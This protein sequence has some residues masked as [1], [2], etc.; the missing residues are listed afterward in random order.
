[1]KL[2]IRFSLVAVVALMA[3]SASAQTATV[4]SPFQLRY[5]TNLNIADSYVNITN[6]G[7]NGA[8]LSNPTVGSICANVYAFSPDQQMVSCCSCLITPNGLVTLSALQDL[9]NNTLTPAK[10]NSIVVKLL[11]TLPVAGTCN[12]AAVGTAAIV[13]GML[14]WGTTAHAL[15]E[16]KVSKGTT[17]IQTKGYQITESP[18]SPA[19]LSAGEL[20]K[21]ATTCTNIQLMGSGFGICG[22]CTVGGAASAQ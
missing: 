4:D 20:S 19:T 18:F 17:T 6:D 13:S 11:S 12:P 1:M 22:S 7:A 8:S 10:P 2:C 15:K 14:A 3:I 21:I 16:I 5:A 9:I